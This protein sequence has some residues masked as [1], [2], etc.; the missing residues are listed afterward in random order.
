MGVQAL[1]LMEQAVEC[2]ESAM[3]LESGTIYRDSIYG[4]IYLVSLHTL[5]LG[6]IYSIFRYYI[7][8]PI[9]RSTLA[10]LFLSGLYYSI[11]FAINV[12]KMITADAAEI[13]EFWNEITTTLVRCACVYLHV[14]IS[15]LLYFYLYIYIYIYI[16]M[17]LYKY[18]HYPRALC[19]ATCMYVSMWPSVYI[20]LCVQ[21]GL[22][23]LTLALLL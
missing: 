17:S 3:Q 9:N 6:T 11:L 4:G 8:I 19:V 2:V 10:L 21:A 18:H 23:M 15:P 1:S 5:F 20:P 22:C 14:H 13:R 7:G 16:Y 12:F